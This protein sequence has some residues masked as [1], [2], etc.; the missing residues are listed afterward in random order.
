MR[1]IAFRVTL[2]ACAL[3]APGLALGAAPL[4][5]LAGALAIVGLAAR[6][7]ALAGVVP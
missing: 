2:L 6:V 4:L 1:L 3:A 5:W 7:A